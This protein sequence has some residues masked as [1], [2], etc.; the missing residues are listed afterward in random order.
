MKKYL[1]QFVS[2]ISLISITL[3]VLVIFTFL[4]TYPFDIIA[5]FSLLN[6]ID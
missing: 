2:S 6:A 4:F 5:G 1:Q 3:T